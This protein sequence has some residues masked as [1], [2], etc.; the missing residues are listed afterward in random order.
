[1]KVIFLV[2][3][4]IF[5]AAAV[6]AVRYFMSDTNPDDNIKINNS[7]RMMGRYKNK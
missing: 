5:A 3:M 1:M 7:N 4:L 6:F 2:S